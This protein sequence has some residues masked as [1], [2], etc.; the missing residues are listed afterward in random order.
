MV[1]IAALIIGLVGGL[2]IG[3]GDRQQLKRERDAAR[4]R[5][6]W[7]DGLLAKKEDGPCGYGHG[8]PMAL[9]VEPVDDPVGAW[10]EDFGGES[11]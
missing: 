2:V 9:A 1:A 8:S 10:R 3:L 7:L 11:G 5:A 4:S 6:N